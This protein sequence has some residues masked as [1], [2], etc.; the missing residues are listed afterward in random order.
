MRYINFTKKD[1]IT[2]GKGTILLNWIVQKIFKV[3]KSLP[4]MLHYTS[5]INDPKGIEIEDSPES[6]TVY[7]CFASSNCVYMNAYN[8]IKIAK[9]VM[10]A[11]G[12]KIISANH[13]FYDRKK[14]IKDKP[15][16]IEE[17]VWI[18][19]NTII[20]PGITIGKNSII[21]GGCSCD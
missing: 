18:G 2:I 1:L 13:D 3:N 17:N 20:L 12:V 14:H 5:R 16:T 4:F 8:G 10:F 6:N 9:N 7:Q 11:S 19:T 21:G 15:I